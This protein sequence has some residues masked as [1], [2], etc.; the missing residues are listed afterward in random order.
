MEILERGEK[1]FVRIQIGM[2]KTG[3]QGIKK[4]IK[5]IRVQDTNVEQMYELIFDA[6]QEEMK[7]KN[8]KS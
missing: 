7:R 6:I 4:P 1:E 3:H 5:T 8:A 2:S